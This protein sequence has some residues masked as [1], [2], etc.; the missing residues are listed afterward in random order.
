MITEWDYRQLKKRIE[1]LE[2]T[3]SEKE[4]LLKSE[5]QMNSDLKIQIKSLQITLDMLAQLNRKFV[6]KL[7]KERVIF[8]SYLDKI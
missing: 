6:D 8:K 2:T 7:A 1:E 3:L 4:L 5:L